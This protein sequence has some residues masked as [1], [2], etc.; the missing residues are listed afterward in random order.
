LLKTFFFT[1]YLLSLNLSFYLFLF[2]NFWS[3]FLLFSDLRKKFISFILVVFLFSVFGFVHD[4]DGIFIIF[5]IAEFTIFLV[6]L[7]SYTQLYS[8]YAFIS[9]K[10]NISITLLFTTV[11]LF[12][13][14][15]SN[16]F[17][18]YYSYYNSLNSV[19]SSDFY[20]LYYLL[21]DQIPVLT[22]VVIFIISFFSLFFI[23][24][25]F[26]L[27][28]VK[29]FSKINYKNIYWLRKQSLLKQTTFFNKIYT[30]Q[31]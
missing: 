20:I 30:F 29:S 5:L 31:N 7:M 2:I 8:N 28:L 19:I 9:S 3:I 27:K 16:S 26:S 17:H 18:F 10:M 14:N 11:I 6:F 23:I 22:L 4:L 12:N 13:Y 21:F 15:V 24:M 1:I 25:Y